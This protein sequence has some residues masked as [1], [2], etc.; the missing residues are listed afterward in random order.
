LRSFFLFFKK[1]HTEDFKP[2]LTT[3]S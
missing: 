2:P 3:A 1:D